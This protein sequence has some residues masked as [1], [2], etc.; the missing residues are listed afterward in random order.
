MFN[1]LINK[2]CKLAVIGLGYVGLPLALAFARKLSVI[3][4]DI[5]AQR[6]E[7]LKNKV[8]PNNELNADEFEN[9][10]IDFTSST[11]LLDQ[12]SFFIIVV[13]TPIDDQNQ[14]DLSCLLK[15]SES[16]GKIIKKGDFVVYESTVY[17]G[18]TEEDCIPVI[19]KISGLKGKF[20]YF[21]CTFRS[22]SMIIPNI[23]LRILF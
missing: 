14:P 10:D 1:R 15:A 20:D 17:P 18:C 19:E 2:E 16:I 6:I 9:C 7:L 23:V 13:P 22:Q 3:G 12:A 5:N 8:D 21:E 11:A 4:F